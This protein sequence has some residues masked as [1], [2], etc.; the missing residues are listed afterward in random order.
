MKRS[1][2][3]KL[4]AICP[5]IWLGLL[6]VVANTGLAFRPPA[7]PPLP[8]LDKRRSRHRSQQPCRGTKAAVAQLRAQFP[9]L[10]SGV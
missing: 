2:M 5:L 10:E 1:S 3:C 7:N 8:N 9:N 6:L 4:V